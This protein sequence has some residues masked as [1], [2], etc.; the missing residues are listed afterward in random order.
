LSAVSGDYV[1]VR[2]D[3]LPAYHLAVVVDDA[4][5]AVTHVVRGVDLLEATAAHAHLQAALGVPRPHYCHVPIVVDS[6]GEK[7]S[8][9]TGAS[10]VDADEPGTAAKVL[11]LLGAEV[12]PELRGER[13]SVLWRWAIASFAFEPLRGVRAL[14]A[15]NAV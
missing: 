8:K 13:P 10:P 4:A 2:R 1:V 12:P 3:G 11:R 14:R 7:L 5:Q 15:S 9:Q 6:L